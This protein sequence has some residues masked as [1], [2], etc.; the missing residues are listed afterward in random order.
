MAVRADGRTA[1]ITDVIATEMTRFLCAIRSITELNLLN[2]IE[3]YLFNEAMKI[4]FHFL[5]LFSRSHRICFCL[6]RR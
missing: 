3:I 5:S 1:A 4:E 2:S 6:Y